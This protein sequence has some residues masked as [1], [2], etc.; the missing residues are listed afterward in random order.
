MNTTHWVLSHP[1]Q[2]QTSEFHWEH[3]PLPVKM[4]FRHLIVTDIYTIE[5]ML[6][7]LGFWYEGWRTQSS[8]GPEVGRE[9]MTKQGGETGKTQSR[10]VGLPGRM[11]IL[12]DFF[13]DVSLIGWCFP[14]H[15][16]I[17]ILTTILGPLILTPYYRW[18]NQVS[19]SVSP[20]SHFRLRPI[21]QFSLPMLFSKV[22]TNPTDHPPVMCWANLERFAL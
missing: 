4:F 13:L 14:I 1:T 16:L 22:F 12:P 7:E 21:L 19:K 17:F 3:Y 6:W 20:I 2:W 10:K 11:P 9:D 5:G 18:V 15:C 8:W